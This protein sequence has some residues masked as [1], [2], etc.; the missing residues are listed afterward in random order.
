MECIPNHQREK[1]RDGGLLSIDVSVE[2][3]EDG[4]R[5]RIPRVELTPLWT[6]NN[7]D[8]KTSRNTR[9]SPFNH[10]QRESGTKFFIEQ[11]KKGIPTIEK[12]PSCFESLCSSRA[13]FVRHLYWK[14]SVH[15]SGLHRSF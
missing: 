13:T 2:H 3:A 8:S 14:R 4:T 11:R 10:S 6:E 9:T 5:I 7:N 15:L 1:T 12:L